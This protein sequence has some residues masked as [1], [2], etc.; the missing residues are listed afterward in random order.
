MITGIL[1]IIQEITEKSADGGYIY[2]GEP[3]CFSEIS[4]RIYRIYH[5]NPDFNPELIETFIYNDALPYTDLTDKEEIFSLLQHYGGDTNY[6]DFTTD[7]L[8]A[9]FFACDSNEEADGRVILLQRRYFYAAPPKCPL[10]RVITQKSVFVQP[11]TGMIDIDND[12]VRIVIV[13]RE[14]KQPVC[15][16]L[17]KHHGIR[18]ETV[19]N[20]LHGFIKLQTLRITANKEFYRGLSSFDNQEYCSSIKHYTESIQ[21]DPIHAGT[22]NN[23]GCV[24]IRTGEIDK[25]IEDFRKTIKLDPSHA[26]AWSNLGSCHLKTGS[27]DEAM[28][29]IKK[30]IELDPAHGDALFNRAMC[31]LHKKHWTAAKADLYAVNNL[32]S[33]R[34]KL[35]KEEYSDIE[36]FERAAKVRLPDAIIQ[37]LINQNSERLANFQI[38]DLRN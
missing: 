18:R 6:I 28:A 31:Y 36:T 17:N 30:A 2:R 26:P 22:W 5:K 12:K 4:S 8:I 3:K 37:L 10:N 13:P 16:Y 11:K 32:G 20:D 27:L 25:A 15:D 19:Y 23:R 34:V 1:N 14:L 33:D 35:F 9:L 21:N 24:Y 38:L 29:A 7:F